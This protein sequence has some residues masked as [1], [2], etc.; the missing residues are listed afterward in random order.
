MSAIMIATITVKDPEKFQQYLARTQEVAAAYGAELLVRGKADRP[1][2]VANRLEKLNA[3]RV[4]QVVFD[5][6]VLTD[7]TSARRH[8]LN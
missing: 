7:T 5:L 3:V 4:R 2:T 1:L 8:Q 6:P